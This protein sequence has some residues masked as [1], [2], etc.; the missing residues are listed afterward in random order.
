[1]GAFSVLTMIWF[2]RG[3]DSCHSLGYKRTDIT[4]NLTVG[5]EIHPESHTVD[6][7]KVLPHT[8]SHTDMKHTEAAI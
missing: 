7:I 6:R 1:M 8:H 2:L 4:I 3:S 5:E